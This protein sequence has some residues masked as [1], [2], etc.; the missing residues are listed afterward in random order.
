MMTKR[1]MTMIGALDLDGADKSWDGLNGRSY[2]NR[3]Q[4]CGIFHNSFLVSN[5][6]SVNKKWQ[7]NQLT[8]AN[9]RSNDK[10]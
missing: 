6:T 7:Y 3:Q 1:R 9:V 5:G 4:N 10:G 8:T 2:S